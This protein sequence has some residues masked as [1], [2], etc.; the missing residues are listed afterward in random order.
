MEMYGIADGSGVLF[1]CFCFSGI[2]EINTSESCK[3]S[4]DVTKPATSSVALSQKFKCPDRTRKGPRRKRNGKRIRNR[5][6]VRGC[7]EL[8]KK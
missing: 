4:S 5:A 3:E 1:F 2:W 6:H 8:N 7:G